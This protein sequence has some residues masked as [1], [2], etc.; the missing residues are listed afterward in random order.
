MLVGTHTAHN[1]KDREWT[2]IVQLCGISVGSIFSS[3]SHAF[4]KLLL[5]CIVSIYCKPFIVAECIWVE[6]PTLRMYCRASTATHASSSS[7]LT[8]A[9]CVDYP[10]KGY[11]FGSTVTLWN[12]CLK[13]LAVIP[14]IW[15][16]M[17]TAFPQ[18]LAQFGQSRLTCLCRHNE[19]KVCV[20]FSDLVLWPFW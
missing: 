15:H 16:V 14:D 11:S 8:C 1:R 10:E 17:H 9:T 19:H 13:M 5:L 7:L 20:N 12:G 2:G 6:H 4:W 18:A 3:P